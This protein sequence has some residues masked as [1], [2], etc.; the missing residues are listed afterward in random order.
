MKSPPPIEVIELW[1]AS[2]LRSGQSPP[3][4]VR[5][6]RKRISW[7]AHQADPDDAVALERFRQVDALIRQM[8]AEN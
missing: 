5:D 3:E 4:I 1:I 8:E 2:R 6:L 7:Y